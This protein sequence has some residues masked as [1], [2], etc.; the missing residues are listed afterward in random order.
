MKCLIDDC[1]NRSTK[2]QMC[3][4]HYRRKWRENN[5]EHCRN[6][7]REYFKSTNVLKPPDRLSLSCRECK[8]EYKPSGRNQKYC[9]KRCQNRWHHRNKRYNDPLFKIR[10]NIRSRLRKVLRDKDLT[11]SQYLGC[12]IEDLKKHLES[13]FQEGMT[14]ENYG[15]WH[16]DHIKP[17]AAFN[18][19]DSEDLRFAC[20]YSN[21]QPL[22]AKDNL[23]K[24]NKHGA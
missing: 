23:K 11:F 14:W 12:T 22:W 21:L 24:G 7:N 10:H 9:S 8:D 6:Y 18:L 15:S 17:L 13:K 20:H 1:D 4:K 2:K 5:I 16:I 3:E 19:Q